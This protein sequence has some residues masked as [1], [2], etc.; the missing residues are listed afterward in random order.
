MDRAWSSLTSHQFEVQPE[1]LV[2]QLAETQRSDRQNEEQTAPFRSL[3]QKTISRRRR[4][5]TSCA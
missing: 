2:I 5:T 3:W 4:E 1:Q